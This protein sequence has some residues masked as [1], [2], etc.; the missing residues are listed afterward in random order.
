VTLVCQSLMRLT[1]S[2]VD[3]VRLARDL[4][5]AKLERNDVAWLIKFGNL[6]D[7]HFFRGHVNIGLVFDACVHILLCYIRNLVPFPLREHPFFLT[8]SELASSVFS[9]S[10]LALGVASPKLVLESLG[11]SLSSP[12][13]KRSLASS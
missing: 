6:N 9:L 5:E 10:T 7:S 4:K 12:E 1:S 2:F 3:F 11:P 13:T 8:L